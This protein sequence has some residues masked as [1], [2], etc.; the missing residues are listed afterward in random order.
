MLYWEINRIIGGWCAVLPNKYVEKDDRRC[1]KNVTVCLLKMGLSTSEME[2]EL[3]S[4]EYISVPVMTALS[5]L[6]K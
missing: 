2:L 4:R 6:L 1:T 5:V 3:S